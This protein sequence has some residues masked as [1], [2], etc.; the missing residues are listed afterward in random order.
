MIPYYLAYG[1]FSPILRS[2]TRLLTTSNICFRYR[3]CK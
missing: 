3:S 1:D 2:P